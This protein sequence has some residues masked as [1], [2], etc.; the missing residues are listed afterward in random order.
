MSKELY[1]PTFHDGQ[2][3]A[4]NNRSR[5]TVL[6]CGR[7]WGKTDLLKILA[8]NYSAK[9]LNIGIFA[10]D[11]RILRE[12]YNEL[13]DMLS[14]IVKNAS[15]TEGVIRTETGGRIDFWSLENERA[16]RSRKYN[17][18]FIDEAAFAKDNTMADIWERAIKPTLLDMKGSAWVFS[19]PDGINEAN[20]FYRICTDKSLGFTEFHAPSATNPYLPASELLKLEAENHPAVYRQEYLAEFVDW[21]GECFFNLENLLVDGNGYIYDNIPTYTVFAV[22]DSAVKS[23]SQHDGTAVLYCAINKHYGTPLLILDYDIIQ[24]DGALLET[25]LPT[26]YENLEALSIQYK[27]RMGSAGVFI[28]DKAS[29]MILLQQALRRGWNATAIDSK[30]TSVGKDERALSVS[31]YVYRGMVKLTEQ[32]YNRQV[33]FKGVSRN[34][35]LSQVLSFRPGDKDAY[36]RA[37]DLLDVFSYGIAIALGNDAGF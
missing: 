28:E 12:V 25:W 36:K 21:S 22:V 10:P 11:Y 9:G 4:Y 16:G 2:L 32:A 20:W 27:A 33:T 13:L 15:K 14:P 3:A 7:R 8:G 31:G 26:V 1:L 37:D 29:G 19:T 5:F 35:L 34:H 18:V 30:L 23:G 6:R 24:I 17:H